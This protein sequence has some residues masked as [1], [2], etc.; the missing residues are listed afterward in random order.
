MPVFHTGCAERRSWRECLLIFWMV[1]ICARYKDQVSGMGASS[2][3]LCVSRGYDTGV[4]QKA[5]S[6]GHADAI[7][8]GRR[9]LATPD[10]VK[11]VE[12]G[13]PLNQYHRE[14]FYTQDQARFWLL[15]QLWQGGQRVVQP[16]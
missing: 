7:A 11:R 1:W 2:D 6:T 12:L 10:L 16:L 14:T 4:A 8:F 9:F 13:K 15:I 5:V 3:V